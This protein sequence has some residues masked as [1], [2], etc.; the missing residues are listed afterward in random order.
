LWLFSKKKE[1]VPLS[2]LWKD[3]KDTASLR[4]NSS[5]YVK[6]GHGC[7]HDKVCKR[8]SDEFL[9]NL[10][11]LVHDERQEEQSA[12]GD[13]STLSTDEFFRMNVQVSLLNVRIQKY[14][15]LGFV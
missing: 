8:D 11:D 10:V 2:K 6:K 1:A 4:A 12:N 13:T 9:S 15:E 3:L 5:T 7:R 14:R